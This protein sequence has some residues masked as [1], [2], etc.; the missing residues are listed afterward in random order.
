MTRVRVTVGSVLLASAI[1]VAGCAA[2]LPNTFLISSQDYQPPRGAVLAQA[3]QGQTVVVA[4]RQG[5]FMREGAGP[6]RALASIDSA[7]L[8]KTTSLAISGS[9]VFV[10]TK[11]SGLLIIEG[12]SV[13]RITSAVGQLPDDR[14]NCIAVESEGQGLEGD[15]V[16]V[17]TD[18]GVAVRRSGSWKVFTPDGNWL[19]DIAGARMPRRGAI[20]VSPK[21][22]LGQDGGDRKSFKPPVTALAIGEKKVV[23][24][25]RNSRIAILEQG[26]LST[27]RLQGGLEITSFLITPSAIWAGTSE[28]LVWGGDRNR[29]QGKPYPSW[30]GAY[31]YKTT[32]YGTRDTRP[33]EYAWYRVGYNSARVTDMAADSDSGLWVSF[34]RDL[35]LGVAPLVNYTKSSGT[36][37]YAYEATTELRRY[38]NIEEY[39]EKGAKPFYE[40]YGKQAVV[41]GLTTFID[42]AAAG[43]G[44]WLGTT[45]GAVNLQ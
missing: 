31:P 35:T 43:G 7:T 17:G 13:K 22:R 19:G 38:V 44:I 34:R 8:K 15:N 20:Y 5:V 3:A 2:R 37:E 40:V 4:T 32:V 36:E 6:W 29:T 16:W 1:A 28:G 33:F 42:F 23:L 18:R 14:V 45:R 10:G 24:G 41:P 39:F 12:D 26:A 9:E 25:S 27:V 21:S 30:R 11:G